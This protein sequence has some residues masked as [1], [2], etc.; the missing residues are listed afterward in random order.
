MAIEITITPILSDTDVQQALK[1]I[2]V[3]WEAEPGSP[4]SY[5]LDILS[6]LVSEYERKKYPLPDVNPVEMIKYR[7]E[8]MGLSRAELARLAFNGHRSRVTDILEGKR[9]L[10]LAMIRSLSETLQ[11]DPKFLIKEY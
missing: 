4:E 7:M 9:K 10:T 1:R 6:L 11:V 3:L 5:E 8:Q 2:E